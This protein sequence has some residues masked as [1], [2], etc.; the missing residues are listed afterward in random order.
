MK[1]VKKK[2]NKPFFFFFNVCCV[3]D[4][5]LK[6]RD[7][8][9]IFWTS[10]PCERKHRR[11]GQD[12]RSPT[13][14]SIK[15]DTIPGSQTTLSG[16]LHQTSLVWSLTCWKTLGA[17]ISV[18]VH[19]S[20]DPGPFP[21]HHICSGGS[22]GKEGGREEPVNKVSVRDLETFLSRHAPSRW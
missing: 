2:N 5:A 16:E 17:G 11:L 22:L 3:P 7:M 4:G 12:P 8:P 6:E 13:P 19:T 21:P 10:N 1:G 14:V 9:G 18:N 15:T 20:D